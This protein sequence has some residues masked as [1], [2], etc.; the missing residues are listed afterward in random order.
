MSKETTKPSENMAIVIVGH[1]DSGLSFYGPF[2]D[3]DLA[4][5]FIETVVHPSIP[6]QW[7]YINDPATVDDGPAICISCGNE[8]DCEC[9]K[10]EPAKLKVLKTPVHKALP[11]AS[12]VVNDKGEVVGQ[13]LAI[14]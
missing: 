2:D 5:E 4:D 8:E 10:R 6:A 12:K 1:L 11:P 14:G 7:V 3:S 9:K 13:Q